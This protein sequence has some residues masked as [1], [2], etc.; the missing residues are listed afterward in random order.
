MAEIAASAYQVAARSSSVPPQIVAI[1]T[2]TRTPIGITSA[3]AK[4]IAMIVQ[5]SLSGAEYMFCIQ[6]SGPRAPMATNEAATARWL[7]IGLRA[8]VG[9]ISE[10][11][12]AAARK[13]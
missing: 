1:Q 6:A 4:A 3:I 8:N 11:A 12:P 2:Y 7:K 13:T 10:I 5:P 9:R